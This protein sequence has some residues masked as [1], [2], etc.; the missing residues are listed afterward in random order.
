MTGVAVSP[1][2][3]QDLR[4]AGPPS[5]L[6]H[7]PCAPGGGRPELSSQPSSVL[8]GAVVWAGHA[9]PGLSE[10]PALPPGGHA[11]PATVAPNVVFVLLLPPGCADGRCGVWGHRRCSQRFVGRPRER[12]HPGSIC[13]RQTLEPPR[14]PSQARAAR[15]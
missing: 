12:Q 11:A 13:R 6:L 14:A 2:E 5:C 9:A 3:G 7:G 15:H 1:A 10:P 4:S 8:V